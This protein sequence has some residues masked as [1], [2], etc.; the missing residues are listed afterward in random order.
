MINSYDNTVCYLDYFIDETIKH[1]EEKNS[2]TLV[3]Y[4]S[5][6]GEILGENGLWLHAQNGKE[7]TNPALLIWYSEKFNK[8]NSDVIAKL[9]INRTK[10]IDLNF[11]FQTILNLYK[12]KGIEYRKDKLIYQ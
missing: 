11:F 7:A 3:I 6:H 12:I 2:N 1:V 5:D 9:K 4:L 8:N 10:K